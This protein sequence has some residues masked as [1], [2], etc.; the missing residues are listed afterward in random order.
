MKQRVNMIVK[1]KKSSNAYFLK[2]IRPLLAFFYYKNLVI[3]KKTRIFATHILI[4]IDMEKKRIIE[5]MHNRLHE[6]D[7][8]AKAILFGSRARGTEHEGSDWD[9]LILL[10]KPKVTLQDYDKYSYP[11]RELGW[12]IDEIINPVLFSQKEWE[13]NHYTL[14]NHNVNKEGIA[15]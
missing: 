7:P 3:R 13:E 11:L 1:A 4:L 8:H 5:A 9:V 15:I 2:D 6:I 14:F 10:D 12:D